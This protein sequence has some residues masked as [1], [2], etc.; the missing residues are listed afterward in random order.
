MK[1][2]FTGILTQRYQNLELI[3]VDDGSTDNT[4]EI[5]KSFIKEMEDRGIRFIYIR[6]N[7]TGIAAA[8]NQG[9][10]I[11]TGDFLTWVDSDDILLPE[12]ISKK[13]E[14]LQ[15]HPEF[16]FA[17]SGIVVVDESAPEKALYSRMRNKPKGKDTIFEDYIL[18]RNVVWSPGTVLV[19][20]ECFL[21]AIPT[22]RIYESKEG[23]NWQLMLTISRLFQCGYVEEPL[24][25]CIQHQ[26]S[27]SRMKRTTKERIQREENFIT[28]CCETVKG[29]PGVSENEKKYW[30]DVIRKS[31]YRNIMKIAVDRMQIE[32]YLK[33]RKEVLM[34]G[35]KLEFR[36]YFS[37]LVSKMLYRKAKYYTKMV[38]EK[39]KEMCMNIKG[40]EVDVENKETIER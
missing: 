8:I 7:N 39:T 18:G 16:G 20:R 27:H 3:F 31:H 1:R 6:Q 38:L 23:Q 14:Y 22:R 32:E 2:Y 34:S 5:A 36:D 19:R 9:L 12:N 4:E 15:L 40:L 29:I 33:A 26:D 28:L 11:F 24:L 25:I 10:S 17:M 35:E 13:V 30:N 37:V 21:H